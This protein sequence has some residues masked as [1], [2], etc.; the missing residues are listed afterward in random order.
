MWDKDFIP[1][2]NGF[3]IKDTAKLLPTFKNS[4]N[5]VFMGSSLAVY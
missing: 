5:I 4:E 3:S 2:E 1:Q